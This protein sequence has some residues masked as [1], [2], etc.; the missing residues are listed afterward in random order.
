MTRETA[1]VLIVGGGVMGSAIAYNLLHYNP[2]LSVTVVERDSTY[3][4]SSTV[5]SDGNLRIQFNLRENILMSLYG[6][7]VLYRFHET[8]ATDDMVPRID[9]HQQGNL[10]IVDEAQSK[11][12]A[13]SG[14]QTQA[15]LGA[16]SFWVEPDQLKRYHPLLDPT[17][18]LGGTFGPNDGMMSPLDVLMGYRRKAAALGAV[19]LEAEVTSLLRNNGRIRGA[20]LKTAA[21]IHSDTVVLAAGSWAKP[22]ANSVGVP[23]PVNSIKRQVYLVEVDADV[24]QILP[25]AVLPSGVYCYHEGGNHFVVGGS[26]PS[27]PETYDDFS[28]S[29]E[30][31]EEQLWEKLVHFFPTFDRLKVV[32]GWAGFYAVNTFDGNA[33]LGEWP[34]LTG[35]FL[36]N[37][38]SG[39]GFQQA[40]AVGR[41]IAELILDQTPFMDLSIFSPRRILENKPVFENPLRII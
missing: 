7:E 5:L 25:L 11:E 19:F 40:H 12:V 24:D 20:A 13:L 31:F 34:E 28:W 9:W 14:L 33:I 4:K 18:C 10:F 38:F 2:G 16:A 36:A 27:D 32:N 41:Y 35:L 21:D 6:A 37:G 15:E 39:H 29:K 22:L 1:D 23:L 8:F 3:E 30:R 26:L 17:V